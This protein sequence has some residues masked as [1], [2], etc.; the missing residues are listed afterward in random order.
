[1]RVAVRG[2]GVV[3]E[4]IICKRTNGAFTKKSWTCGWGSGEAL[5]LVRGEVLLADQPILVDAHV[6]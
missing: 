2:W 3:S 6:P 4:S 1:M 5:L